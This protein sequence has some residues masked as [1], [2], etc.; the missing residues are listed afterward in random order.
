MNEQGNEYS[1]KD[2]QMSKGMNSTKGQTN[3][4]YPAETSVAFTPGR[5][6]PPLQPHGCFLRAQGVGFTGNLRVHPWESMKLNR[7]WKNS[8]LLNNS[9]S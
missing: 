9:L 3:G 5:S 1:T 4:R 7:A 2:R 8:S 6:T